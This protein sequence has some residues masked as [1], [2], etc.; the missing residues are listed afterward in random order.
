MIHSYR[1]LSVI[2]FSWQETEHPTKSDLTTRVKLHYIR[3]NLELEIF[4]F[5]KVANEYLS[6]DF[7]STSTLL[8][9]GY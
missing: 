7:C 2:L 6:G 9:S 1:T 5:G 8:S 4:T 3:D